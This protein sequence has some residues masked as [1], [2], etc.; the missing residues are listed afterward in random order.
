MGRA[1][2]EHD[3]LGF[4]MKS[5]KTFLKTNDMSISKNVGGLSNY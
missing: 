2:I 1:E 4:L 5:K 3:T